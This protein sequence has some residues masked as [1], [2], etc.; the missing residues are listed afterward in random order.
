MKKKHIKN[1]LNISNTKRDFK[2]EF[3]RQCKQ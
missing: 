1:Y 2:K 3:K